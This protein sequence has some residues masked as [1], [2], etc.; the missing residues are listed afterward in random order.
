VRNSRAA[1]RYARPF[2]ALFLAALVVCALVPFNAW[3]F[4]DWELF[5]RLRTDRQTGWEAIA[6][7]S[8]GRERDDPIAPYRTFVSVANHFPGRSAA[9]RDASCISWLHDATVRFGTGTRF[10]RIY[11][12]EWL[13]SDRRG[14]RAA[15]RHRTLTWVCSA[16]GARASD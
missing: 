11:R 6:V 13:L 8:A 3:P 7:D 15:S 14:N 9:E 10:V 5:S 16:K 2:V 12:L 1:P 4:S